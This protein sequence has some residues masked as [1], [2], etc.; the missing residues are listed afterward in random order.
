MRLGYI[1]IWTN[2]VL[3]KKKISS[4]FD[5]DQMNNMSSVTNVQ[6]QYS[7]DHSGGVR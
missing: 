4:T 7:Q 1:Y 5:E 3:H 2:L 6:N